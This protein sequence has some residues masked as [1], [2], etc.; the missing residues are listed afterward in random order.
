MDKPF[1][2]LNYPSRF[3]HVEATTVGHHSGTDAILYSLKERMARQLAELILKDSGVFKI[4]FTNLSGMPVYDVKAD[5]VVLTSQ[6]FAD[7][8]RNSFR[9]GAIHAQRFAP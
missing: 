7:L 6:E 2:L 3:L 9:E 1:D 5:I 4:S 8:K